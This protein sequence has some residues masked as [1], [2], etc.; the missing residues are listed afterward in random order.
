MGGNVNF[1]DE[2]NGIILIHYDEKW[3][4]GLIL[5]VYKNILKSLELTS[6]IL[7]HFIGSI[8]IK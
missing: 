5:Q 8:L 4:G 7:K 3:F 1:L 6:I 2:N